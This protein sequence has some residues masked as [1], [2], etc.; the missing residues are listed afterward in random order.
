MPLH[1]VVGPMFAGKTSEALRVVRMS[2]SIHLNVL[3]LTHT[4]DVRYATGCVITHDFSSVPATLV[5]TLQPV[6]A[7]PE[8]EK[9]QV[10][11]I[12]EGQFFADLVPFVQASVQSKQVHVFGLDGDYQ[13]QPMGDILKLCPLADSFR[14][15][16]ALCSMCQDGT[17]APFTINTT[18]MP[19]SGVL[20]G[21]ADIYAA[22][23]RSHYHLN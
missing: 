18:A 15:I 14:K 5:S 1:V 3:V 22:V 21:G 17:E 12:E 19:A 16:N 8:Y 6:L 11:V 4:S 2:R 20:V 23:C 9:A 10:I 7:T 13:R